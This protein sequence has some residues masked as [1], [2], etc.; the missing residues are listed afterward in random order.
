[1]KNPDWS[2]W[3]DSALVLGAGAGAV[4]SVATQQA[5]AATL[6]VT[7]LVAMGLLER[8]RVAQQMDELDLKIATLAGQTNQKI[9]SLDAKITAQPT[10]ETINN[11]QRAAMAHSD[12]AVVRISQALE[13]TQQE[14][15]RKIEAIERPDLSHLYQ[16][17]AQLQDQYTYVCSTLSN[18]KNQVQR[19]S[20]LPRVE[21]TEADVSQLK[22]ELMQL[23][24]SLE[25]LGS[26][27]KTAQTTL[28][29]AIRHLDRR[30]RQVPNG[31]DPNLLKGEVRELIKAVAE[32]VPRRDFA[33][34]GEKFNTLKDE[35]DSLRKH[36]HALR[37]TEESTHL[38][39]SQNGSHGGV[40]KPIKEI[41]AEV[42]HLSEVVQQI[43]VR[44]NDIS[45][46]FDITTEI[47]GTTATYINSLQWQ[48][49]TLEQTAQDL[50]QRYQMMSVPPEPGKLPQYLPQ[51]QPPATPESA[52]NEWLMAFPV[53]NDTD[54]WDT[55]VNQ[56]LFQALDQAQNRVVMVWPWSPSAALDAE[57]LVRFRE[58]LERQCRLEIGWCHPSDRQQ[59]L[60]VQGI[61]QPWHLAT[62]LHQR[63]QQALKQLLPLKQ[64]YPD[65]F[66]FKVL[67][68][69][70]QFLV[71][72]RAHAIVGLEALPTASTALP[73]LDVRL[74]TTDPSVIHRLLQR[75]DHPTLTAQDAV[76]YFN[77]AG[78]R[79]DLKDL[80][81][82]IA[83]YSRLV[84]I[85]PEDALAWNN[86]GVI[87]VDQ[88]QFNPA[89]ADFN[90]AL[91]CDPQSWAARCNRG[92]VYSQQGD[93]ATA[94]A[95]WTAAIQ[96]QPT[97]AIPYF[98]RGQAYQKQGNLAAAI[99]DQTAA[100]NHAPQMAL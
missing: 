54:R 63:L 68:T 62:V 14:V 20:S 73:N 90:Q 1:M 23:R 27:S 83:D 72:D 46:P 16:D 100:I 89:L 36:V 3:R 28:Q 93:Y 11:L 9:N 6:P 85:D 80:A 48:L 60:L 31:S 69:D 65:H 22:T 91:T 45:V 2:I 5:A 86:R 94:I 75:F 55:P 96:I 50:M 84:E 88:Q 78:T 19:L 57:V 71:C 42:T 98:Y 26:E 97:S 95:D 12:R 92:W 82:A 32:L 81:G 51:A 64:Q 35:Q 21:A 29:D 40:V 49:A 74:R 4:V 58:V 13:R 59:G 34:L 15:E 99:A 25:S 66:K 76:A 7:L 79:Y 18:L 47:R 30:L 56:A 87:W 39:A 61:R 67:G 52:G 53:E 44:L 37:L 41:D 38:A 17:M 33:T 77:R 24:V 8:R 10:P 43:E 70:E